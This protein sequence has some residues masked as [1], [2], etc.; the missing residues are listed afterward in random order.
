MNFLLERYEIAYIVA[1]VLVFALLL[2]LTLRYAARHKLLL[3][4]RA[5]EPIYCKQYLSSWKYYYRKQDSGCYV[6]T[7]YNHKPADATVRR[8]KRFSSIYV[9]QSVNVYKRVRNHLTGHGNGDVYADVREN[10]WVYVRLIP[11]E[12]KDMNK[13]EKSLISLFNATKYYNK[14]CGGSARRD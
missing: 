1:G 10:K 2:F 3:K 6:I 5:A 13:L 12:E 7:I 14:T 11:C 8:C 9:G 4:V